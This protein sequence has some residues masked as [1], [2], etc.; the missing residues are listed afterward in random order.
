VSA[1]RQRLGFTVPAGWHTIHLD[2]LSEFGGHIAETFADTASAQLAARLGDYLQSLEASALRDGLVFAG[3]RAV[4][5]NVGDALTLATPAQADLFATEIPEDGTRCV[6]GD[7]TRKIGTP[8]TLFPDAELTLHPH[9]IQYLFR[10][11]HGRPA[12]LT[13]LSTNFQR[14]DRLM[15]EAEAL[16]A[17]ITLE[18]APE[19]S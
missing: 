12:V 11:P 14:V 13:A 15:D 1:Q 7:S 2:R 17:S 4:S 19:P 9:S 18:L 5:T 6:F 10:L 16:I 3:I 8:D